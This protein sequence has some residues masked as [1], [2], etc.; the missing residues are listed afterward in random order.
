MCCGTQKCLHKT[1]F[2]S[3][4]CLHDPHIIVHY[5]LGEKNQLLPVNFMK[6]FISLMC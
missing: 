2:K 3:M 4:K 5:T 6:T 1:D